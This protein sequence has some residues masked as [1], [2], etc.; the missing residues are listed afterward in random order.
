MIRND[1]NRK[2]G[3]TV[4][5][6]NEIR[7]GELAVG[8]KGRVMR[9]ECEGALRRRLLDMGFTAG[10]CVE[11]V[12]ESPSSDPSAYLVKG[13][14]IALR[15]KDSARIYLLNSGERWNEIWD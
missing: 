13:A 7:L 5:D 8:E 9:L 6:K 2:G 10:T 4:A 11:K 3:K 12:G 1:C 14:V 15:K